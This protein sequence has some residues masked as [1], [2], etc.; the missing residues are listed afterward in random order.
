M[1]ALHLIQPAS[2]TA[3]QWCPVHHLAWCHASYEGPHWRPLTPGMVWWA[4]L[5]ARA[6]GC[7][8]LIRIEIIPCPQCQEAA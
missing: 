6:G 5:W 8:G 7:A 4:L 2:S 3:L 1:A